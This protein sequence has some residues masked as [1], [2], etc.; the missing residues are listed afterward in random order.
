VRQFQPASVTLIGTR[1]LDPEEPR[2]LKAAG[3]S[4]IG[5]ASF[6]PAAFN[7]EGHVYLH[8]DIDVLDASLSPG[9]NCKAPGGLHL[10]TLLQAIQVIRSRC[11]IEAAALTNYNAALD[12]EGVTL[13][14][15]LRIAEALTAGG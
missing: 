9:A 3:V 12:P 1:D 5:G 6:D 10:E 7:P 2:L 13:G 15:C 8:I 11:T 14:H 4:V